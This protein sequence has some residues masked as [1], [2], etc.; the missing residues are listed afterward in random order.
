[1]CSRRAILGKFPIWATNAAG[2]SCQAWHHNHR[3]FPI[4]KKVV[5]AAGWLIP[6]HKSCI[7]NYEVMTLQHQ[8]RHPTPPHVNDH[9]L[10]CPRPTFPPSPWHPWQVSKVNG[11]YDRVDF[12]HIEKVSF[13]EWECDWTGYLK[14]FVFRLPPH[15]S[16]DRW[17]INQRRRVIRVKRGSWPEYSFRLSWSRGLTQ[18]LFNV[19]DDLNFA[20]GSYSEY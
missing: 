9:C 8:P 15:G 3:F 6:S 14:V 20:P 5:A 12:L 1:M 18:K 2:C 11:I 4:S 17:T 16:S 13:P 19:G 10:S 7:A